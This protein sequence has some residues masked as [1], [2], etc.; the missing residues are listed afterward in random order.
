[1]EPLTLAEVHAALADDAAWDVGHVTRLARARAARVLLAEGVWVRDVDRLALL[2][3]CVAE[4]RALGGLARVGEAGWLNGLVAGWNARMPCVG[5][6]CGW[7]RVDAPAAGRLWVDD[8]PIDLAS[9][10]GWWVSRSG[11]RPRWSPGG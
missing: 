6:A 11:A 1:M 8:V 3:A 7:W 2:E 9:G 5:G 4:A 10:A